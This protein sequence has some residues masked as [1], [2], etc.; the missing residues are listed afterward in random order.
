MTELTRIP[1]NL[2]MHENSLQR[3]LF[4]ALLS[5]LQSSR[6]SAE[7]LLRRSKENG[8]SFVSGGSFAGRDA[9]IMLETASE[10]A[11]DPHIGL[12]LG[13]RVG[14]ESYGT[15]GFASMTCSTLRE[16]TELLLR[17]GKVFFRPHWQSDFHEGGLLLWNELTP[18]TP[19]Q[20]RIVTELCF[21]QMCTIGRSLH[22]SRLEGA[23]VRFVYPEPQD[24]GIYEFVLDTTVK[25]GAERNELYL[26]KA[27]LDTPV[28]TAN[29]S[30]HVVFHRQCDEM[31]RL[32]N[33]AEQITT[34]V[35]CLLIQS[36]GDFLNISQVARRLNM[37]ERT[38]RRRLAAESTSFRD[39]L[40]EIRNLLAQK[41]LTK[42]GLIVAEIAFLLGYEETVNFRR[43]FLRWNG[44]T[45]SVFREQHFT[46]LAA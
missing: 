36:A 39:T 22:R 27:V 46:P 15:F 7:L 40:D 28:R 10:L 25:F 12:R 3:D 31:L 30:D 44:V 35:R 24:V 2:T 6:V 29:T 13:Q 9:V 34:A 45:P 41:Y 8:A 16:S 19:I 32:L 4:A 17:Y 38:L 23:E 37:S 20:H 14:I 43:A 21:S 42:T 1:P 11:N 18:A 26:P 5:E 33:N